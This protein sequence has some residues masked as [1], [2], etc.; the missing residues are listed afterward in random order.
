MERMLGGKNVG[1]KV[2]E[3]IVH[4]SYILASLA[5]KILFK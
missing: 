5:L 1:W 4:T 3:S 2:L